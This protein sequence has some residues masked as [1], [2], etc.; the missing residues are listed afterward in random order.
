MSD[1]YDD[2]MRP[3]VG[4]YHIDTFEEN[5][6]I[7]NS[8]SEDI[9]TI[10]KATILEAGLLLLQKGLITPDICGCSICGYDICGYDKVSNRYLDPDHASYKYIV[11]TL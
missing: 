9:K 6:L 10:K 2:G 7:N 1:F 3:A 8:I 5:K 4:E 11:E